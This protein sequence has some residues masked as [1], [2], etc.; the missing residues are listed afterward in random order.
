MKT[1]LT[2]EQWRSFISQVYVG[3]R[4]IPP[5]S[6]EIEFHMANSNP[7]S[8]VNGFNEGY[9]WKTQNAT[10]ADLYKQITAL[11]KQL[12]EKPAD[13]SKPSGDLGELTGIV[14]EIRNKLNEVFK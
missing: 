3:F 1:D 4:G 11:E 2:P 13:P 14:N 6:R 12:A 5:S 9:L 8:F 10:I 7:L